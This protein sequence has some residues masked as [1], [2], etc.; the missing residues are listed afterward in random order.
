[1]IEVSAARFFFELASGAPLCPRCGQAAP[2][3]EETADACALDMRGPLARLA[4]CP[5]PSFTRNDRVAVWNDL[6]RAVGEWSRGGKP[7]PKPQP[8]RQPHP[9]P[10]YRCAGC[11]ITVCSSCV[12]RAA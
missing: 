9:R 5:P 2:Y 1:M 10:A 3:D 4:D 12:R 8:K 6:G 7:Q 11:K